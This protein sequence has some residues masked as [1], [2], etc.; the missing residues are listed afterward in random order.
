MAQVIKNRKGREI[1]SRDLIFDNRLSDRARFIY[2]YMMAKP[3]NWDFVMKPM[4]D[5]LGYKSVET[6]RKYINEL[7]ESG[8][9]TKGEQSKN[10]NKQFGPVAYII[11]EEPCRKKPVTGKTRDGKNRSQEYKDN[12]K[13]Y[14]DKDN[15]Q[16]KKEKIFFTKKSKTE[17]PSKDEILSYCKEMGYNI[18][19]DYFI[20]YYK[21][22]GWKANNNTRITDWS[23]AIDMWAMK[24][25]SP[26]EQQPMPEVKHPQ[27]WE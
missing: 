9:I 25:N 13:D 11:H 24:K 2:C 5:E 27:D 4:A 3:D 8:W 12:N 21:C 18:D 1:I 15:I 7:V 6:L 17:I 16:D 14:K 19:V 26:T 10:S 23:A 20:A 22:R